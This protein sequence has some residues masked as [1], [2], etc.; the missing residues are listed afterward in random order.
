MNQA[1]INE[2]IALIKS[3]PEFPFDAMDVEEDLHLILAHYGVTDDYSIR[4]EMVLKE[5]LL[6]FARA[7]SR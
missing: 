1:R 5:A 7:S 2:I 6:A 4:D 3:Q